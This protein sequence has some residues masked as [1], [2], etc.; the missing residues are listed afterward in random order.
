MPYSS[1]RCTRGAGCDAPGSTPS[2]SRCFGYSGGY[3]LHPACANQPSSRSHTSPIRHVRHMVVA[4][5]G[6]AW[7]CAGEDLPSRYADAD[8]DAFVGSGRDPNTTRY[9]ASELPDG[10]LVNALLGNADVLQAL[11]TPKPIIT[12]LNGSVAGGVLTSVLLTDVVVAE[13]HVRLRDMHVTAG[14]VS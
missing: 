13:R 10:A 9:P 7:F 3:A 1:I 5:A 12:A 6:T 11:R 14:L 4:G 8:H 2:S